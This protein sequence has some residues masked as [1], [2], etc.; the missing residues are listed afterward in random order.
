MFP[1]QQSEVGRWR[2]HRN[3]LLRGAVTLTARPM[4]VCAI[5]FVILFPR[6]SCNSRGREREQ[7]DQRQESS[8]HRL[9]VSTR[10]Q[11]DKITLGE[12]ADQT[13]ILDHR[14]ASDFPNCQKSRGL[15]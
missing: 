3:D 2:V 11:G 13:P 14:K 8:R 15:N 1:R 10:D 4:A 12:D 9:L 5:S 6:L 7:R